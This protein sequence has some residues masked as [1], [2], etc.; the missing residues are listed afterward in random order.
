MPLHRICFYQWLRRRSVTQCLGAVPCQRGW[1]ASGGTGAASPGKGHHLHYLQ[2]K[3]CSGQPAATLLFSI[4]QYTSL[5]SNFPTPINNNHRQMETCPIFPSQPLP[6]TLNL[7]PEPA[8]FLR[9][10]CASHLYS[11]I[12]HRALQAQVWGSHKQASTMQL[13]TDT[14]CCQGM[15]QTRPLASS[16]TANLCPYR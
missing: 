13:P 3:D 12:K 1:P 16:A 9:N 10:T 4:H 11:S 5:W 8:G 14:G 7:F 15:K 2:N 6:L